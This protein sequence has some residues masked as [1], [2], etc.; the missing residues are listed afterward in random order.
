MRTGSG[1]LPRQAFNHVIRA[2]AERC[3]IADEII[4]ALGTRIERRTWHRENFAALLCRETRGNKRPRPVRRLDNDD[5]VC[6]PGDDSVT[7]RKI[8][9]TR[10]PSKRHLTDRRAITKQRF[11]NGRVISRVDSIKP[12]G[13][14][15]DGAALAAYLVRANVDAPRETRDDNKA[16]IRQATREP[17]GKGKT[18]GGGIARADDGDS[19]PL[20]NGQMSAHAMSGGAASILAR[21]DEYSAS[22]IATN[23]APDRAA[24]SNSRSMFSTEAIL[25]SRPRGISRGRAASAALAPP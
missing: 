11:K 22:P 5:A 19:R 21:C 8:A 10:L 4:G 25:A 20:E 18:R 3:A 14:N 2:S 12:T 6:E 7:A 24:A 15:G 23:R 17:L 1:N 13:E 9:A 16:G